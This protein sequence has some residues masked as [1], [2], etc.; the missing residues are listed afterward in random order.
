MARRSWRPSTSP[1][2]GE[3]LLVFSDVHLGS[4]LVDMGENRVARSIEIDRDLIRLL[5]HYR[6]RAPQGRRWRVVVAGDFIDFIGMSLAT[7]DTGDD[8]AEISDEEREHGLGNSAE[9]SR[10]KLRRVLDRHA[11]VFDALGRYLAEGHAI[12][13]VHGNHDVEL[14]WEDVRRDLSEALCR[15]A[16]GASERRLDPEELASRIEFSPWFFYREGIVYIE[17]GHQYDPFCSLAHIM[18]PITPTD[19]RHIARGVSDVLLRFVVRQTAGISEHG[20]EHMGTFDYVTLGLRMGLRGALRL[21][22]RFTRA[23]LELFRL[24]RAY[25]SEAARLLRSE[26]EARVARLAEVS[27]IGRDRMRALLSLQVLPINH[28]IRGILASVLLDRIALGMAAILAI[29]ILAV[30]GALHGHAWF[31]ALGVLI[32]WSL[33][34][35]HLTRLRKVDPTIELAARAGDLSRLFPAAFVV[36]GHTH[37]PASV[38]GASGTY[39][40]VGSWAEHAGADAS[41]RA[42]RT[43]LVIHQNGGRPEA[44]FCRWDPVFGPIPFEGAT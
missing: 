20:H 15:R 8:S 26:H 6:A 34:H 38:T 22:V 16:E 27:R 5:E 25:I 21:A 17:H 1:H 44:H 28:S 43:H 31:A 7:S 10:M 3:S 35:R 23:V 13:F 19:P 24:R 36:M 9:H 12:T 32:A 40:N 29:F 37:V 2:P 4:D 41:S 18:S 11:E 14:H 33:L 30:A 42:A 39:I